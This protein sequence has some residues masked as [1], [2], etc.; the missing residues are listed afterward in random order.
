MSCLVLSRS[1]TGHGPCSAWT[2]LQT[3]A[4]LPLGDRQQL[5]VVGGEGKW[6]TQNEHGRLQGSRQAALRIQ[7]SFGRQ[8]SM[9]LDPGV[10]HII[11]Q[12]FLYMEV[13]GNSRNTHKLFSKSSTRKAIG[14][15]LLLSPTLMMFLAKG[16]NNTAP[17]DKVNGRH[18]DLHG[19]T[20]PRTRQ[21]AEPPP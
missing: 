2:L 5:S 20:V 8:R 16:Y 13:T 7:V 6:A 10:G 4:P 3:G 19:C 9:H 18:S 17:G 11:F 1:L 12:A 14:L 21:L 15:S